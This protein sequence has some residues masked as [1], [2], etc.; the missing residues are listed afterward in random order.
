MRR[1]GL[2][3]ALI[4]VEEIVG[5]TPLRD[6]KKAYICAN[7]VP[8][9]SLRT[10]PA[11]NEGVEGLRIS[12]NFILFLHL[13]IPIISLNRVFNRL[14]ADLACV[15]LDGIST[16]E[17][18]NQLG[19]RDAGPFIGHVLLLLNPLCQ[20]VSDDLGGRLLGLFF[21]LL[22]IN[23]ISHLLSVTGGLRRFR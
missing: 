12:K 19:T 8:V 7:A 16:L 5:L 20:L 17:P 13:Y 15:E 1:G 10:V 11:V 23:I 22:W 2:D 21:F 18:L 3:L 4:T 6:L 14:I 9:G